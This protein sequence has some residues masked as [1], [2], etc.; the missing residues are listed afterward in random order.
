MIK[1]VLY[2]TT[3]SSGKF[4]TETPYKIKLIFVENMHCR[5]S[6]I[7]KLHVLARHYSSV[8]IIQHKNML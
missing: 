4:N 6:K 8:V 1:T 2:L 3:V 5:C 7:C